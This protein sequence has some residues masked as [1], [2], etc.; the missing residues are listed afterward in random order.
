MQG[1][2]IKG[3]A[4]FYYVYAGGTVYECKA[5]GAFR[6][7]RI[8]PLVG[9][10]VEIAVVDE[11]TASGSIEEIL[12][13]RCALIRPAVANVDQAVIVFAAASPEPNLN[14]LDRFLVMMERQQVPVAICINKTDLVESDRIL[15]LAEIYA[16]SG[17]EVIFT[18]TCTECGLKDLRELLKGKTTTL[19]GPSGVGKSSIMNLLNPEANM[20]VGDISRK[21]ER[22]KHTTRHS[23]MFPVDGNGFV[24]DTPGFGSIELYD[25]DAE[26]LKQYYR[27]FEEYEPQCRF[28]GC[29]HIGETECGVRQ[30]VQ[31]GWISPE[32][33]ENYRLFFQ[34]LK[35]RRKY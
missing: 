29:N 16:G 19:A 6:K 27:E 2:I 14:L 4:G 12:P 24:L 34:E 30:A 26:E 21:I 33:Y 5:K 32:R 23:E 22:G 3:I 25:M 1:K 15:K 35:D 11:M 18:S 8:K 17:C 28:Q 20:E 31:E 13:R 7:R 9:D 10:D